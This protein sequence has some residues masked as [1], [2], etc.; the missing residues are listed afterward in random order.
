MRILLQFPE[1]LKQIALS[2]ADRLESEGHEVILSASSCYGACDLP[3]EEIRALKIEKLIHYGHSPFP[4]NLPVGIPVEY[5]EYP[6]DI[7]LNNLEFPDLFRNSKIALVSTVQH[8]HQ[9]S[10]ISDL[11]ES[12]GAIPLIK[13]GKL[14]TYPG[15]VLGCDWSAIDPSADLILYVGGG[16]FHPTGYTGNKRI[17]ALRPSGKIVELTDEIVKYQRKKKAKL[18]KALTSEV[19]GILVSTKPGQ[20]NLSLAKKIASELKSK[21]KKA[22]ILSAN[23]FTKE[24]IMNF[25]SFD[26]LIS[27]ACP[28]IAEDDM[29]G[30]PILNLSEYSEFIKYLENK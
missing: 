27:T 21:E 7:P 6:I 28:R 8:I 10:L 1:G 20:F 5:K 30:I 15:Q 22:Y 26:I 2:E 17:F 24:Q 29:F 16:L 25:N 23:T 18:I 4:L 9:I 14:T 3:L 19:F 12:I 11:L 13:K